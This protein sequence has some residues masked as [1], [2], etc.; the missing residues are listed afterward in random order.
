MPR[1]RFSALFRD[2][3]GDTPFKFQHVSK[4]DQRSR[5]IYIS[6]VQKR[7]WRR[8]EKER[9]KHLKFVEI[10]FY[11]LSILQNVELHICLAQVKLEEYFTD[12]NFPPMTRLQSIKKKK[13][14]P[15]NPLRWQTDCGP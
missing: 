4:F 13:K 8:R 14:R 10:E 3:G 9:E 2:H 15:I 11:R 6:A 1:A 5:N 7:N 12:S